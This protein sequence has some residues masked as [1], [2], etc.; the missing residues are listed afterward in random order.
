LLIVEALAE[1]GDS[2]SSAGIASARSEARQLVA[3]AIGITLAE[4]DLRL[5][6]G[7]GLDQSQ[8][9]TLYSALERRVRREPLQHILGTAP[10][11]NLELAVG[12]GVFVPRPETEAVAQLAIDFLSDRPAALALDVGTG[13]G[14]IALALA[15]ETKARVVAIELSREAAEFAKENFDRYRAAIELRVGD[16]RDV[17]LDLHGQLDVLISNPP[18][19]PESAIP[20]DPEVRDYDPPLALYSGADGLDLIRELIEVA[21]HLLKPDGLLVLEHAD[22]QSDQVVQLLLSRG[23]QPTA[24]PDATQRLRAVTAIR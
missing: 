11:R 1:V 10:F 20:I 18:Y 22:G 13:S 4:L 15:T 8:Q 24:H 2:L 19:I 23:W 3:H 6:F 9:K 14:A 21:E 12:L 16:F 5:S 7:L 17:S